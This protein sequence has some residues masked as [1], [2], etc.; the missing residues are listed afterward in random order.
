MYICHPIYETMINVLG[1]YSGKE[2]P[3][4]A[5][6]LE[7]KVTIPA[8]RTVLEMMLDWNLGNPYHHLKDDYRARF[9]NGCGLRDLFVICMT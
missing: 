6:A 1:Q 9:D 5:L 8:K 4:H 2:C 7:V 3:P